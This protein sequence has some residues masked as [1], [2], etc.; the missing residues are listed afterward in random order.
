MSKLVLG[1]AIAGAHDVVLH[2][3][4]FAGWLGVMITALNLLPVGQ[5]DGGHV[6]H[7][8]LG[9]RRAARGGKLA[10]AAMVLLGVFLWSGLLFW[11]LLVF[12]M[13]GT[14]GVEPQDTATPLDARRHALAW[15]TFALLAL[16]LLPLPHVLA[17]G[18][19]VHCPYL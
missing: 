19:G 1:D 16:I 17:P 9:T 14:R 4:A 10:L 15:V 7:A 6:A 5:L 12:T 13:G 3:L 8:L 2:P 18:L 11:A